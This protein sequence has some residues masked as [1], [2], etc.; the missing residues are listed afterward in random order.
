MNGNR[1]AENC[2]AAVLTPAR[3][4][5]IFPLLLVLPSFAFLLIF[6]FYP[7][8][9][10][11]PQSLFERGITLRYF[12]RLL[13]DTLA[14]QTLW[15][16]LQLAVTVTAI[17]L[18]LGYPV[19]YLIAQVRART[20]AI[21]M[22]VVVLSFWISVLV[23]TY[24]WMVLLQR[25]GIVNQ[26]LLALGVLQQPVRLM[27]N[28]FAVSVGMVHIL[29]PFMIL[30]VY[31]SLKALDT[32]LVQAAMTLGASP[33]RTF[34]RVTLPLTL[35]GVAAGVL[36]VFIQALG[37]YVTPMLLGGPQTLMASSLID[38]HMFQYLDWPY[39]AAISLV[40][41]L[42][43]VV[44]MLAFDRFFGLETLNRRAV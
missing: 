8:T 15:S 18:C 2:W 20:A 16:T 21:L 34:F 6:Y 11:I 39:S 9:Y 4:R 41:L 17:T 22:A 13:G 44:F 40:L 24:A 31:A 35:N 3:R 12:R 1:M 10:L 37:F 7:L 28:Q 32:N 19:A 29:L 5:W 38:R 25:F 30:P 33:A 43:T 36:L 14:L 27:Y 23:R 26:A 42:C